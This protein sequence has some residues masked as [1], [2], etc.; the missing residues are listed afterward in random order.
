MRHELQLGD[1]IVTS[2]NSAAI[3]EKP[4]DAVFAADSTTAKFA[5]RVA[6]LE[7]WAAESEPEALLVHNFSGEAQWTLYL[8]G[9]TDLFTELG[10]PLPQLA[11]SSE[12][13][14]AT[15][16]SGI[17]VTMLGKRKRKVVQ[18]DGLYWYIYGMPLVGKAVLEQSE[19]MADLKKIADALSSG[20]IQRVWPVGSKG[21]AEEAELLFGQQVHLLADIDMDASAGPASCVLIGA[22]SADTKVLKMH[23]GN[24]VFPISLQE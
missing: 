20:L 17:A 13:N 3:G 22:A 14:M 5:A 18:P 1:W 4:A 16:Q 2:D 8:E 19:S 9:I 10:R 12:T 24:C 15:L 6:L 7:Q 21:I 23:F 11:G